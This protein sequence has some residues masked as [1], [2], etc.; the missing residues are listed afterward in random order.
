MCT[1]CSRTL[2]GHQ[3][4]EGTGTI[5]FGKGFFTRLVDRVT[6]GI[7]QSIGTTPCSNERLNKVVK[8]GEMDSA[9]PRSIALEIPS[10]PLAVLIF[11]VESRW[12]M[13]SWEQVKLERL[14]FGGDE[15]VIGGGGGGGGESNLNH[16]VYVTV[17]HLLCEV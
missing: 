16:T 2:H 14:I 3:R 17:S 5:V 9:V 10:G 7:F 15:L 11:Q 8:V 1:R 6:F 4:E 12:K 13:S